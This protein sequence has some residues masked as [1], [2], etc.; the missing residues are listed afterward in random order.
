ME[1]WLPRVPHERTG[2]GDLVVPDARGDGE[3]AKDE[4]ALG[5]LAGDE[6]DRMQ[7]G[8]QAV[9]RERNL[10]GEHRLDVAARPVEEQHGAVEARLSGER[11]RVGGRLGAV[12]A[13]ERVSPQEDA[14]RQAAILPWCPS[15]ATGSVMSAPLL[16][17][18][19]TGYS[20]RLITRVMT[21]LG[22]RPILAGRDGARLARFAQTLGLE[23]R[24]ASLAEPD[25]L[26]AALR[27]VAV[28]LHAAGPFSATSRPVV[29]ACLRAGAHYV[30]ITGEVEVIEALARR[31]AEARRRRIMVMPGIGFDVV[32]GDC[33][34][35]HVARRLP[36]AE[37]LALAVSGLR[38]MTR[39][40][41]K[42]VV[43]AA[44]YRVGRREGP[45]PP[46]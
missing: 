19:A 26:D 34:A 14:H 35:A 7:R 45:I 29:E 21:A 22:I 18:G 12:V 39:G 6:D 5:L 9:R 24:V 27:D 25:R 43:E 44:G 37:R 28:V 33:L 10:R 41:A 31:D 23:H 2:D 36:E 8:G 30:D 4:R 38:Y 32:A 15:R 11:R 13:S 46:V 16:I 17:Y 1:P 3:A 42:S 20:G 40:T